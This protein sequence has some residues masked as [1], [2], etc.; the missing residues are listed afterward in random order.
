MYAQLLM[1]V[2]LCI[3]LFSHYTHFTHRHSFPHMVAFVGKEH[4]RRFEMMFKS[5]H[6]DLWVF[7]HRKRKSFRLHFGLDVFE[8]FQQYDYKQLL[9]L[10]ELHDVPLIFSDD[11][12]EYKLLNKTVAS[13]WPYLEEGPEGDTDALSWYRKTGGRVVTIHL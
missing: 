1:F 9:L 13:L 6:A 10:Y 7:G 12:I 5:A 8:T 11:V 3:F 2:S 4:V